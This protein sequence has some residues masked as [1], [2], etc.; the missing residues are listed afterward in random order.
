MLMDI[1]L[2]IC[3]PVRLKT[4]SA[5]FTASTTSVAPAAMLGSAG[6][7]AAEPAACWPPPAKA[8]SRNGDDP[9]AGAFAAIVCAR[10]DAWLCECCASAVR[11]KGC[12]G[13]E[14]D[15]GVADHATDSAATEM[16]ARENLRRTFRF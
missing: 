15:T 12:V 16:S 5:L 2:P 6:A 9:I 4:N 10:T 3:A 7:V 1:P 13:E 8:A 11:V 14:A